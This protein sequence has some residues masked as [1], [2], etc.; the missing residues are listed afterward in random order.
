MARALSQI[1]T[2]IRGSVGGITFTA[3][4]WH[5]ILLRAKTA[6][7]QPQTSRQNNIKNGFN[8]SSEDWKV[9]SPADRALWK[10]Y[11]GTVTYTGPLGDYTLPG[12]QIFMAG[13]SLVNYIN[14]AELDIIPPNLSPPEIPGRATFALI[15]TGPLATPGTGFCVSISNDTAE[16]LEALIEISPAFNQTRN[17]YKGPF[18]SATA[19]AVEIPTASFLVTDFTGLVAD[20]AYFVRVRGVVINAPARLTKITIL[21]AVATETGI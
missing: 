9:M 20:L 19:V 4:Q 15:T 21:R 5:Q 13:Q 8:M 7:V 18:S 6:P 1:V 16:D 11:G 3:N 17:R 2:V 12:R 14:Q 10:E